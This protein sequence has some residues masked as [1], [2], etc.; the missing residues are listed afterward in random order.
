[1]NIII[2][3]SVLD[4]LENIEVRGKDNHVRLVACMN[5]IEQILETETQQTQTAKTDQGEQPEENSKK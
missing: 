2:L 3:K 5:A 4:T 1:M